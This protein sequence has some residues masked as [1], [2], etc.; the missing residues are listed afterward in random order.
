MNDVSADADPSPGV[1]IY[2]S[3]KDNDIGGV[4]HWTTV[5]GTSVATPI[6][7][8]TYAL[9][10]IAAGGPGKALIPGTFP[11]AYPYQATSGLTDIQGGSNGTCEPA[12]QYLCHAVAGYDGPTGLGAP[13]GTAAFTVNQKSELTIADP[14]TMVVPGG[15]RLYLALNVEPGTVLPAFST[16]PASLPGS[17]FVDTNGIL[18]GS[19]PTAP[20]VYPVTVTATDASLGTGSTSFDVVVLPSLKAAHPGSG[21]VRLNAANHCL[22]AAG[23]PARIEKCAGQ[24]SQKWEFIAGGAVTGTGQLKE[25]GKC[26]AIGSSSGNGAKATVQTCSASTRQQWVFGAAGHL[27]NVNTGSCLS[28]RGSATAGKQAVEWSCSGAGVAWVLPAAPVV[29]AVPGHC[30]N[31]PGASAT[32]GTR[33]QLSTCSTAGGQ[34]WTAEPNGTLVAA[35]RCLTVNGSSMLDGAAIVLAR[36]GKSTSQTWLRGPDGELMS[37]HSGLCLADPANSKASG[38]RLVQED[39]YRQPGEIWVIT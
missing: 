7:A 22:T 11:A 25:R 36:C 31:D 23:S 10:D 14:G 5:G 30:L 16:T 32:P 20:G 21:E 13:A 28:I 2:D 19:A 26:L 1:A 37:A 34:K 6:V 18:K 35:G 27:R 38:T 4:P 15:A 33:V 17:M 3:V 24:A 39:C 9:A 12:R 8:A 29:S